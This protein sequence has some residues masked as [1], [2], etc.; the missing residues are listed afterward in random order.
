MTK[1]P[2]PAGSSEGFPKPPKK[3]LWKYE[4]ALFVLG[5]FTLMGLVSGTL[6][7]KEII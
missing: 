3:R 5:I 6:I 4:V 1:A 2:L 7:E